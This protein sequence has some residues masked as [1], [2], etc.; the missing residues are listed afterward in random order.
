MRKTIFILSFVLFAIGTNA[1]ITKKAIN[2][3][4]NNNIE[5]IS[6]HMDSEVELCILGDTEFLS[7]DEATS[8]LNSFI[9]SIQPKRLNSIHEGSSKNKG[10]K[11]GVANLESAKGVYRLFVFVED[12]K[13][14][15]IIREIRIDR[16]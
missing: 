10:S 7:A 12:V 11:Y 4:K 5:T 9:K 6:S 2:A 3:I 8:R 1:Q 13:N 14:K 15:Q 16:E